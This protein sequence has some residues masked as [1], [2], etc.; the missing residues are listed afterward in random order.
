MTVRN[1]PSSLGSKSHRRDEVFD[2]QKVGGLN[3][4]TEGPLRR[5]VAL[6]AERDEGI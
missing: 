2:Q 1:E 4:E 5:R 6:L 3:A